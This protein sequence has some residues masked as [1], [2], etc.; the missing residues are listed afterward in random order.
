[1]KDTS[2]EISTST[3][4]KL[5]LRIGSLMAMAAVILGAF[6][7]HGLEGLIEPERINT[8][9]IGVRYHFYHALALLATSVL[10]YFGKKSFLHYAG[11]FFIAGI[12]LF[13]GSLYLLSVQDV[14][15]IPAA[16]LG[17]VTPV[18]GLLFILGWILFFLSTYQHHQRK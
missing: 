18:G 8:Y 13:S 17:P 16:L 1:M 2:P 4:R 5:F 10:L 12:V 3:M 9:E 7:S 6:G 15:N 14:L 11:W